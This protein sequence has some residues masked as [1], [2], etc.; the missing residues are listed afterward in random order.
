MPLSSSD[1]LAAL[2]R[3]KRNFIAT[4]FPDTGNLRRELYVK[5]ME[6]F[7]GGA[8]YRVRGMR[9]A[10]RVGKTIAGCY[11][12]TC[13]V[14]GNYPAWWKGKRFNRSTNFIAAGESGKLTRDSLQLKLI[15]PP[16][17]NGTGLIPYNCLGDRRAKSGI[18]EAF[19]TVR[20][21]HA[22]GGW[23]TV[24]FQSFDQG[25]EAFQATE[26]DGILLDEEP[27]LSIYGEAITRTMTTGGIVMFTFT[28]LK[29]MTE[30]VLF[31]EEQAKTDKCLITTATWDDAPHLSEKDK[32]DM[33]AAYPVHQRDAR[34]K[35]IPQLGSG[36]IYPIPESDF[37]VAPF[38]IPLYWRVAYAMDVGWNRTACLWGAIDDQT[39]TVYLYAEHYRGQAEPSVHADA[40]K[41]RG[42]D[43]N[44][45][46]DPAARGR[47]QKDGEQLLQIYE[48]LGLRL[49]LADNGVE[50]G[51]Y[52]VYQ[53]KSTGRLKVFSTLQNYLAEHRLYRRD[54]KGKVVK[55][56][57][58]LM[59]CERYFCASAINVAS[60]SQK[61]IQRA[62]R[63][64]GHT[65][66]Y[67]PLSMQRIEQDHNPR[68]QHSGEYEFKDRY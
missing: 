41:A 35:G 42:A 12:L 57:D 56:D 32:E 53:R 8:K 30:T 10:N 67:D 21:R 44:G 64:V 16:G 26:R 62:T 48:G 6:F 27:P 65:A 39:D 15:G 40:I 33:L 59:D 63:Q 4:L 51:I 54:E 24:Q 61:Y 37:V 49:N 13:H 7:E 38:E 20:V 9:C 5:H 50:S 36:A 43:L 19:D 58:H 45:V 14:T 46:I 11:E 3:H 55:T 2:D 17:D 66:I 22:S 1:I 28:P 34:S 18:P 52:N 60:M 31:L 25:R 29:G 47:A 23:S 68:G